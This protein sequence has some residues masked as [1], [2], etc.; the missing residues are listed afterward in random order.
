MSVRII[1]ND[2]KFLGDELPY[3][4]FLQEWKKC[5]DETIEIRNLEELESHLR[6]F[7][8]VKY[9]DFGKKNRNW[10]NINFP[11][12]LA[13]GKKIINLENP[14]DGI[15]RCICQVPI[16]KLHYITDTDDS[17]SPIIIIGSTCMTNW[18]INKL[19]ICG[20]CN[21]DI[22]NNSKNKLICKNCCSKKCYECHKDIDKNNQYMNKYTFSYYFEPHN[23]K[24][25]SFGFCP[26][27][28]VPENE[29]YGYDPATNK[30]G[31]CLCG[32]CKTKTHKVCRRC[33][34]NKVGINKNTKECYY[35]CY[36][37]REINRENYRQNETIK[38]ITNFCSEYI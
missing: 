16:K 30:N 11:T 20:F 22:P 17:T 1:H 31:I 27:D 2:I 38:Q 26:K 8:L 25:K 10:E 23:Q 6:K 33:G 14:M 18:N 19:P 24:S 28:F 7:K 13:N 3:K 21:K 34:T 9:I 32:D 36:R 29:H 37:C 12:Y 15:Q 5:F 35:Y 4:K